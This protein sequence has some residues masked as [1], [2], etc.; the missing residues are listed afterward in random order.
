MY[1]NHRKDI[2]LDSHA[3]K[4]FSKKKL[5]YLVYKDLKERGLIV[6]VEDSNLRLFD[7]NISTK[8]QA[9]AVVF[10]MKFDEIIEL[11]KIINEIKKGLKRRI[12]ISIVDSDN[13]TVYYVAKLVNWSQ[14]KLK[15]G[16]KNTIADEI[17]SELITK[18]YKINSGLKFGAHY[19]VYDYDSKHAPWLIQKVEKNTTWLDIA[20]MVR[21]GH[22]VNKTVV[23]A[24]NNYWISFDWIKP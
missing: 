20:R 2:K 22:G 18:G 21:V 16:E 19:R 9:S 13:D 15:K 3:L 5:S 11:N 1:C 23:L 6:K 10:A 8:G 4:Q 14:T 24:Y 7:R 17:L 12:Q